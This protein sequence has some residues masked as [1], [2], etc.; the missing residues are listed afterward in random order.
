[1]PIRIIPPKNSAKR[2]LIKR[3]FS[4]ILTPISEI[5]KRAM[6]IIARDIRIW[7]KVYFNGKPIPTT[8]ASIEVARARV[9]ITFM[10]LISNIFSFSLNCLPSI[11]IFIPIIARR[12]KAIQWSTF[13]MKIRKTSPKRLPNE[14]INTWNIPKQKAR[15]NVLFLHI[16]FCNPQ[17]IDT[18][19]ESIERAIP[20]SITSIINPMLIILIYWL[21]LWI[22]LRLIVLLFWLVVLSLCLLSSFQ[23]VWGF[24]LAFF[25]FG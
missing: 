12:T 2:G 8:K 7:R 5:T 16:H 25:F 22:V 10:L 21:C 23:G 1:M 17:V 11:I 24:V 13:D 20:K 9:S 3:T 4:P 18:V 15:S 19:N 6:K 14:I